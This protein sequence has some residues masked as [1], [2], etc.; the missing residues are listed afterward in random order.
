MSKAELRK[1]AVLLMTL[2]E[3]QADRLL[4]RLEP[5]EIEAVT[6]EMARVESLQPAEQDAVILEFTG[7]DAPRNTMR[8]IPEAP[9]AERSALPHRATTRQPAMPQAAPQAS[10]PFSFLHDVQCGAL[11]EALV[12]ERTQTIALVASHV[13]AAYGA[14]LI[15]SLEPDQQLTVIRAV[16]AMEPTD[17]A[18]VA[19]VAD[20]LAD[21]MARFAH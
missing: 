10:R 21:R 5:R 17:P 11:A 14:A 1:A 4:A 7:A 8:S 6:A 18:T 2:S 3:E 15:A 19:A 20:A 16:A 12:D 9:T 13:P